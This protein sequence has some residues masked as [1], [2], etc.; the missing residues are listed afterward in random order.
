[1]LSIHS[2]LRGR[3]ALAAFAL[4]ATASCAAAVEP[5]E[6]AELAAAAT[7]ASGVDYS[8]A[9]PSPAGLQA[10]GYKFAVRYFS[11]T[12]GG[13][14]LTASEADALRAAG[15][16][17]VSNWENGASDA[18]LGHDRGAQDAQEALSLATAAGMPAGR[19]IYFSV[20]FDATPGQ[21][22]A[23][24]AYFDG[25]AS[26]LGLARTGAY[27][28]FYPIQR[29]FDAG[30]IS[31]GW[32]TFA[33]SGGQW[34]PRA[35]LRQVQNGVEVA[36]GDCDIDQAQTTDWGQWGAHPVAS[37]MQ[38]IAQTTTGLF[39]TIR[40]DDG[41]TPFGNVLA[42]T[43]GLT[44]ITDVA[45]AGAGTAAH[46]VVAAGD[47]LYHAIRSPTDWTVWGNVEAKSGGLTGISA[48]AAA[49]IA[50]DLQVVVVAGGTIY[51]AIR[52]DAWTPWGNV[53]T[54]VGALPAVTA[55]AA[56]EVN[57]ELHLLA[58]AGDTLWHTIRHD[59]SWEPWGNVEA[60]AGAL[61]GIT[62]VAA[63]GVAGQLQVV[64]AA[65]DHIYHTLRSTAWSAWGD[66]EAKSGALPPV[67]KLAAA[68]VDGELQ[69]MALASGTI[70]HAIRHTSSWTPW[71]NVSS[72]V[73][74]QIGTP[75]HIA[76]TG[77]L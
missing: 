1:M 4:C 65:G 35:Q 75:Q 77:S 17:L 21:Q 56:A 39:H 42:Q 55:I 61:T 15:V 72:V 74:G 73:G 31:F 47:T 44:G 69:V 71:G 22:A 64:V 26:V 46:I 12:T 14:N 34:E 48:V 25:V 16:D 68:A 45:T 19:P 7:V 11:Y 66:V 29:L 59:T 23:I 41:W 62:A 28:G 38:L 52:S 51:H 58:V 36:G 20:D 67:T 53:N 18:L 2:S 33:W 63:A 43:G 54:V 50:G 3:A 8:F 60:K 76:A 5:D 37:K 27:G 9:R 70:Y 10:A 6:N 30:K 49:G 13:K 57:G 24:N 40:S 32:Q